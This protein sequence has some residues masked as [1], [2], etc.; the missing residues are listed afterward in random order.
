MDHTIMETL[1]LSQSS[2]AVLGDQ[3]VPGEDEIRGGF[4][5]SGIRVIYPQIS[6][7]D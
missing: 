5:L 6:R 4:A 1:R 3:V 7:A 2:A